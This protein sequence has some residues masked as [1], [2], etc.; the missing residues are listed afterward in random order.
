MRTCVKPMVFA[1]FALPVALASAQD[2]ASQADAA[3]QDKATSTSS[4]LNVPSLAVPGASVPLFGSSDA[5]ANVAQQAATAS[6]EQISG[7]AVPRGNPLRFSNGIFVYPSATVSLG[8]NDNLTGVA[9]GKE[10]SSVLTLA[11]QVVAELKRAGDR[12]A[13]SYTGN[14]ARHFSSNNDDF[15][16]H[17]IELVGQQ[18]FT[19]RLR[20][21]WGLS[22]Q[23]GSDARGSTDTATGVDEPNKWHS[24]TL[25][26]GLAYGAQGA[27]GRL[28]VDGSWMRKR[29][30]NNRLLTVASDVDATTLSSTFFYRVA[31]KTSALFELRN[32]WSD[33]V[34]STSDQDNQDRRVYV[35]LTWD[36]TAKTTGS[37]RLGRAYKQFDGASAREDGK[38]GTWEA[39][40]SWAPLTYSTFN[41]S[42]AK[43]F[44]DS[45]GTGDYLENTSMGLTWT[46]QWSSLTS[47]SVSLGRVSSKY[48]ANTRK[49][50][51]DTLGLG[52]NRALSS[53]TSLGLNWTHSER[54]TSGTP[55]NL[56]FKRNVTML[57]L[58]TS[59]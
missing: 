11:P 40:I 5:T 36:A 9:T 33:Y 10:S 19:A 52:L 14:Y 41:L 43:G 48:S 55:T 22:Y 50:V 59:L 25:R 46:H 28:Q 30:D 47:S 13:L 7:G 54:D 1:I 2:A 12:Y 34:L 57:Q 32:T 3:Q 6:Y 21:N 24:T 26:G 8:H 20:T 38:S 35:G 53:N 4:A 56:D 15:A 17:L 37:V 18:V 23:V 42:T 29:F 51:T 45:S 49:D 58:Q 16:Q 44:A 27:A 39:N 31:P